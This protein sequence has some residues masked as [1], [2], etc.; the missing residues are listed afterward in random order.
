M[1]S[2][3]TWKSTHTAA[4]RIGKNESTNDIRGGAINTVEDERKPD[5]VANVNGSYNCLGALK[6]F[7]DPLES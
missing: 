6:H 2:V 5:I 3:L 7:W 4:K 1:M